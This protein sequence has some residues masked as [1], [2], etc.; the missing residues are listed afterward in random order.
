MKVAFILHDLQL[1]GGV[2]VVIEHARRLSELDGW[3]VTLVLS[4]E[5]KQT[6]WR[7]Y[8][9]L[10]RIYL[11]PREQALQQHFD[12]AVAT[13]W[14]T[15]FTLFE[16]KAERY[17]Y[18][19]QSLEDRFY[20]HDE[21]ERIGAGL[22]LDLPV[23]FITEARWI[24]DTLA[25]VRPGAPCHLVRNGIDKDLFAPL[26]RVTP[27]DGPL[28]VLVE[29]PL[30]VWFKQVPEALRA[31]AA[32][33][34]PHHVTL[35]SSAGERTGL[36]APVDEVIGPLSHREMAEVYTQT[37][38]LLKL[39]SVEGMFGP[40]LEGFHRGAT[41]VVTPV[42]GH[43]EYIRHGFNALLTDWEDLRGTARQLDLLARDRELLYHL[44]CNA[45]E[46]ARQWPDWGHASELMAAALLEIRQAPPPDSVGASAQLMAD[47]RAAIEIHRGHLIERSRF[48]RIA[49]R[50]EHL[51]SRV[52]ALRRFR[53]VRGAAWLLRPL[54]RRLKRALS[55]ASKVTSGD[56]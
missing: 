44:R 20:R 6:S 32:M 23:S 35:I 45:L 42:T 1:S 39:S 31:A 27:H 9:H 49:I 41:C 17:A 48:G 46:T 54:T 40:P 21:A 36:P 28:R 15:A 8:E 30:Q 3:D 43:D 4:R 50:V 11:C 38:V 37:D 25:L 51:I 19:V 16:L 18:F 12:V 52:R 55:G 5:Q 7:G 47:L 53:L 10:S 56:T 33:R 14:E 13:W 2:G 24:A 29:G 26:D 34:E 22:T